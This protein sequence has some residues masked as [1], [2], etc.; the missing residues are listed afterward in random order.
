MRRTLFSVG[1]GPVTVGSHLTKTLG[2][3][4]AERTQFGN[5]PLLRINLSIQLM[6]QIFLLRQLDF[7]FYET[8]LIWHSIP[9]VGK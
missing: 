5:L 8:V 4:C 3:A 7:D 9:K 6:H 2:K 1:L